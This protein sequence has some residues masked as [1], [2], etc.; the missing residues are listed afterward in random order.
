MT[1]RYLKSLSLAL[2]V[3]AG[4][5]GYA[6]HKTVAQDLSAEEFKTKLDATKDAILIDLRTP[7]EVKKGTLPNATVIDF[8]GKDFEKRFA[9]LDK[10]KTYF[11]YCA[12]GGRSGETKE[13]MIQNGFKAVYNMPEGF[14]GWSR[15]KLPVVIK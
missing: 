12:S 5:A 10:N 8:F 2:F 3:F 15:K 1:K 14:N 9:S 7:E 13:L 4:C 6:Q 11:I